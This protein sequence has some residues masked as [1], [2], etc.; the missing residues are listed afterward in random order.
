[1]TTQATP[2]PKPEAFI[3]FSK[4]NV[5]DF[6][7]A[8]GQDVPLLPDAGSD[9][10]YIEQ[11]AEQW[12]INLTRLPRSMMA[13]C[14]IVASRKAEECLRIAQEATKDAP[15]PDAR[16]RI[17]NA[18]RKA[19]EAAQNAIVP[20]VLSLAHHTNPNRQAA[21]KAAQDKRDMREKL[22]AWQVENKVW[23]AEGL[24]DI[25]FLCCSHQTTEE[26]LALAVGLTAAVNQKL[27]ADGLTEFEACHAYAVLNGL[28]WPENL[29]VK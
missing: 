23:I 16:Y 6:L 19:Q 20:W 3:R 26:S 4:R 17:A 11:T 1:M 12:Q 25:S 8:N 22:T 13:D 10:R 28:A 9:R 7:D 27:V 24:H 2:P 14:M 29:P 5:R 21:S 15:E 18:L